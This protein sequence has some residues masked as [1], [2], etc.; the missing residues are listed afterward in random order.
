MNSKSYERLTL[1]GMAAH[2]A[3]AILL[4]RSGHGTRNDCKLTIAHL[5]RQYQARLVA[6]AFEVPCT[7]AARRADLMEEPTELEHAIP[8][9]CLMNVLFQYAHGEVLQD[10]AVNVTSLVQVNTILSRVT[11]SEH[12]LLNKQC[13]SSMPSGFDT[14]PWKNVWA[15]YV[16]SGVDVPENATSTESLEHYLARRNMSRA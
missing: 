14:Y 10:L 15:R 3:N 8:V 6:N 4:Y 11:P 7:P 5:L 2:I 13:Q 12:A 9:G 1:D 16:H